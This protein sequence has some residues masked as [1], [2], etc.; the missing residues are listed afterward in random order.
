MPKLEVLAKSTMLK[1]G[2]T[3]LNSLDPATH[4]LLKETKLEQRLQSSAK[5]IR[6][7]WP[8]TNFR[9][10]DAYKKRMKVEELRKWSQQTKGRGVTLFTDDRHGNAWL[11]NPSLLKPSRF[12]MALRLRGGMTSDKVT[13]NKV[14][15]QTN[16]L[17]RK[18][19]TCNETLAHVLGQCIYTKAQR[20]RR[21][22]EIRDAVSKKMAAMKEGVKIIEES[23]VPTPTGNL[24]PDLVVVNQGRVHV[25]D[26]TVRHEDTGR[27]QE[28]SYEVYSTFTIVGTTT[29]GRKRKCPTD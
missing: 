3:L 22:D 27:L 12:L 19:K 25:V 9:T 17:C 18:C 10:I 5:A 28:Q 7:Q 1:Q 20:I 14:A 29:E 23:L 21:H 2:I 16:V 6:I 4:A 24:K 8:I 13:M 26:I 15:P 11:Y